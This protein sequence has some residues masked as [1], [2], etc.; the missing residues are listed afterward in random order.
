[1]KSGL[2]TKIIK[3]IL[4][5]IIPLTA[6][7]LWG[8]SAHKDEKY[9]NRYFDEYM[10]KGSEENTE[11]R[12]VYYLTYLSDKLEYKKTNDGYEFYHTEKFSNEYGELF[13]FS[14]IR[15]YTVQEEA[16]YN[17]KGTLLGYRDAYN[18]TYYF[19][20]YN[21]NYETLAKTLDPSGSHPLLS[22]ELPKINFKITNVNEENEE[23]LEFEST[24]TSSQQNESLLTTI[25]DYGYSPENDSKGNDLNVDNP[26]HMRYYALSGANLKEMDPEVKIEIITKSSWAEDSEQTTEV[27]ATV[28]K[29]DLYDNTDVTENKDLQSQFKEFE[30]GYKRDEFAA[31]YTKHAIGR[32]IWWQ[33]L[34][35]VVI[36]EII[37][38]SF[39]LVWSTETE[40]IKKQKDIKK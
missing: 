12:L 20:V 24:T 22:N 6:G 25:F 14:I 5:V 16:Y 18:F 7:T 27:V 33:V 8:V 3:F 10:E 29:E 31:G 13:T 37:C 35:V 26:T 17:K 21:I 1:M 2:I 36:V 19:A 23:K 28:T 32:Y 30:Q 4:V 15:T 11:D 9:V 34:L 40:K 38:G 39:V